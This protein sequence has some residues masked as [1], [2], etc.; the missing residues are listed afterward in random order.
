M[1]DLAGH[2]PTQYISRGVRSALAEALFLDSVS[3]VGRSCSPLMA[4]RHLR[5]G[6]FRLGSTRLT[7][8]L[9]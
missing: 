2:A 5:C 9:A 3:S 4:Q 6:L 8:A 7:G 1:S